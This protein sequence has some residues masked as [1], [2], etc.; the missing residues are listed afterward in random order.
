MTSVLDVQGLGQNGV[1]H[2]VG[3]LHRL[4]EGEDSQSLG[5]DLSVLVGEGAQLLLDLRLIG[6]QILLFALL[7]N[8][9][10]FRAGHGVTSSRIQSNSSLV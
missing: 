5:R 9:V 7:K 8:G 1:E 4:N 3:V 6:G 2:I 10:K